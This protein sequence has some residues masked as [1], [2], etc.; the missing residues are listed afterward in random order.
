M[1]RVLVGS[2][3][4]VALVATG[5]VA[6]ACGDK[7]LVIGRGV[8][9]QRAKGAVQ[10]A[11]ILMYLDPKSELPA[12]MKDAGLETQLKL[13]GHKLHSVESRGALSTQLTTGNYDLV[14]AGI[15]DMTALEPEVRAAA[16]KPALLPII[17]N[18]TGEELAA[19]EKQFKCVM[20]SPSKKQ[21]Y[22][23]VI[24][25]ALVIRAK[26]ERAAQGR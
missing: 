2:L 13:A 26:Q 22:L 25:D 19:A 11:S 7:F 1:H 15:S 17:Y 23:A 18:P 16:S 9:S 20:K 14:L 21:H 4:A 10:H 8:R 24:D 5:D 6:S 12:A 3:L